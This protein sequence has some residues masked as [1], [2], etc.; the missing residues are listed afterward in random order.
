MPWRKPYE[1]TLEPANAQAILAISR[2]EGGGGVDGG[3]ADDEVTPSA[4]AGGRRLLPPARGGR[5]LPRGAAHARGELRADQLEEMLDCMRGLDDAPRWRNPETGAR[6]RGPPPARAAVGDEAHR[7]PSLSRSL[8]PPTSPSPPRVRQVRVDDAAAGLLRARAA[9]RGAAAAC[10][11]SSRPTAATATT[12]RRSEASGRGERATGGTGDRRSGV[13]VTKRGR[14]D[15]ERGARSRRLPRSRSKTK[16]KMQA[17]RRFIPRCRPLLGAGQDTRGFRTRAASPRSARP[18]VGACAR[19]EA[20]E[21][22][23]A[24]YIAEKNAAIEQALSD[25][26]PRMYPEF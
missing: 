13:G 25:L 26:R 23:F 22:D 11:R 9:A 14:P 5:E 18:A 3:D 1:A 10:P 24:A 4:A 7:H 6:V 15:I 21:L 16:R 2:R 17:V 19:V 20:A 12:T 8:F